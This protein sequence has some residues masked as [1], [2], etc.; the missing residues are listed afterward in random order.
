MRIVMHKFAY[1]LILVLTLAVHAVP[2]R[3]SGPHAII[4]SNSVDAPAAE[5]LAQFLAGRGAEVQIVSA[6]ELESVEASATAVFI[7]GGPD[8]YE[9]VGN[10]SSQFLT[11][12]EEGLLR[13]VAGYLNFFVRHINGRHYVVLAG[14]TREE[15]YQAVLLFE[16]GGYQDWILYPSRI[17]EV[18][19]FGYKTAD[20]ASREFRWTYAGKQ[21]SLGLT[22]PRDL[23]LYYTSMEHT[24]PYED[25]AVL[26]SDPLSRPY[27]RSLL[28]KLLAMARSE[29]FDE[30]QTI[31]FLAAFVQS[32]PYSLEKDV[33][34]A[35]G[36]YPRYPI[37]TLLD[38][39]GDCEDHAILLA[40]LY[41]EM[42]YNVT[43]IIIWGKPGFAAGHMGVGIALESGKGLRWEVNGTTYYYI[44]ATQP[45]YLLGQP[46][47]PEYLDYEHPI[48]LFPKFENYPLPV[49]VRDRIGVIWQESARA[50]TV[51]VTV[52]NFGQAWANLT[53]TAGVAA[54]GDRYI[55]S[56]TQEVNI[57]PGQVA[58]VTLTFQ[59]PPRSAVRLEIRMEG[60]LV[61]RIGSLPIVGELP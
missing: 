21:Y 34:M 30:I 15:T 57:P 3:S 20:V 43:L 60:K 28:N 56:S 33:I 14:H 49:L 6:D 52:A 41:M 12:D 59:G 24:I 32:I 44:D 45:G 2:A 11:A 36:E 13:R 4:V 17:A 47:L 39:A 54:M 48:F 27:L 51:V 38:F 40:T 26:A 29:G 58:V 55:N 10:I 50:A 9:G 16:S 19:P 25:W 35:E 42:G 53:V 31:E 18:S 5:L 7:L 61:D 1:A 8:A 23:Y 37:E 22:V 46:L